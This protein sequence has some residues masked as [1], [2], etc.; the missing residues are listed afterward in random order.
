MVKVSGISV[1]EIMGWNLSD[2][3]GIHAY[4]QWIAE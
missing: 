3:S 2:Q 1:S 4:Q